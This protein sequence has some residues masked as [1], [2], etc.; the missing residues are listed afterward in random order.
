MGEANVKKVIGLCGKDPG[1]VLKCS[2]VLKL[3]G[4]QVET[5]SCSS[6]AGGHG[7]DML[8]MMI[9]RQDNMQEALR[10][11]WSGDHS[12]RLPVLLLGDSAVVNGWIGSIAGTVDVLHTSWSREELLLRVRHLLDLKDRD[13]AIASL[14]MRLQEAQRME[15]IGSIAAGVVHEFNNLMFALLGYA[16][17]AK[18]APDDIETLRE[19]ADVA[20]QVAR[21]ASSVASSLK[22]MSQQA[23]ATDSIGDLNDVLKDALRLLKRYLEEHK[24]EV[25][26]APGKLP[27]SAFAHGQIQQVMI[28]L[29]INAVQAMEG[30]G[31]S[32]KLIVK[33]WWDG[34]SRIAASVK[35]NGKGMS[36]DC[37]MNIFTPFFTTKTDRGAGTTGGSGLGLAI[38]K[39]V[40]KNHGGVVH[41]D[42]REGE[43]SVFTVY[44]P[45]LDEQSGAESPAADEEV[46]G[47]L[48]PC[49][50]LVVDDEESNLRMTARIL[51]KGG[52]E[53]LSAGSVRE[54]MAHFWSGSLDLIVLDLVMP[55][56]DG[57]QCVSVLRD[58]GI[59][60][61]ILICTGVVDSPLIK[62]ALEAGAQEVILK[63]FTASELLKAVH[64]CVSGEGLTLSRQ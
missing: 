38:V 1:S 44:L 4:Y 24:V 54:A 33:T 7:L 59:E 55:Q 41:V 43:G 22:A 28:N 26:Y 56:V 48:H 50:V 21:R 58:D 18:A 19:C 39:E 63:P 60:T 12:A 29:I 30:T 53:V 9:D 14:N 45:V 62:K 6:P 37:M 57:A 34:K 23:R 16:E 13:D 31:R 46:T 40:V 27:A 36:E 2:D 20:L 35:D 3:N 32:G 61:P 5:V 15:C 52:Y 49:R 25:V 42:S 11:I 17:M 10:L 51:L 64:R 47:T 8:I